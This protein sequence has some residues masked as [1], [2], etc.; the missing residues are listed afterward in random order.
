MAAVW[1]RNPNRPLAAFFKSIYTGESETMTAIRK[2]ASVELL[3]QHV[4]CS[5][6]CNLCLSRKLLAATQLQ[7][8]LACASPD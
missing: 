1:S 3:V 7:R 2:R 4:A 6:H 5:I 8:V